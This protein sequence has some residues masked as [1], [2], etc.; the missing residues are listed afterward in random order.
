MNA[1]GQLVTAASPLIGHFDWYPTVWFLIAAFT[2]DLFDISLPRG[3]A[4]GVSG[5]LTAAALLLLGPAEAAAICL[6]SEIL[7][8]AARRRVQTAQRLITMLSARTGA[9]IAS[10]IVMWAVEVYLPL[11]AQWLAIAL[12]P[13]T[14]LLVELLAAQAV[15]SAGTGRPLGRLLSGNLYMQ[16]PLLVAQWSAAELLLITFGRMGSWS[17]ILVVVLLL[18]MRQ[19]YSVL[20]EIRETYRTTVEV[21]VEAAESQDDRRLGHSDRTAEIARSIGMRLGLNIGEVERISYAALLHDVDALSTRTVTSPLEASVRAMSGSGR[22]S[23]MFEGV[24]FF[25]DVL[26]VLRLCDGDAEQAKGAADDDLLAAMVVALASDSDAAEHV[27]VA[28][29]HIW[30]AVDRVSPC[31]S[32]GV[33]AKVVG[34]A[35]SLGYKIP[36]VR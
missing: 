13:A 18:L 8:F 17:L 20:L 34:A 15:T 23:A 2:L 19:S 22:S 27:E 29:A 35:L 9:L 24:D 21:L 14:F 5:A 12:V 10:A 31:V 16:A 26:P 6:L 25:A 33:K 7:A 28:E 4:I 30:T 11:R 32:S 3:D 1:L 36:A